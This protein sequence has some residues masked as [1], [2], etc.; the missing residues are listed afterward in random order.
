MP[1]Q[2]NFTENKGFNTKNGPI[3]Q[4]FLYYSIL[5]RVKRIIISLLIWALYQVSRKYEISIRPTSNVLFIWHYL[6][7]FEE[8]ICLSGENC[9]LIREQRS[10]RSTVLAA[11]L[12]LFLLAVRYVN[13]KHRELIFFLYAMFVLRVLEHVQK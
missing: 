11:H 1:K 3:S 2:L 9:L 12:K 7:V 4:H 6:T 8:T 5:T 10:A 13:K